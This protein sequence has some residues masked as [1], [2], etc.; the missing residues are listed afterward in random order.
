MCPPSLPKHTQDHT[1]LFTTTGHRSSYTTLLGALECQSERRKLVSFCCAPTVTRELVGLLLCTLQ[2]CSM[3]RGC[4]QT[5]QAARSQLTRLQNLTLLH[6]TR[7]SYAKQLCQRR[8]LVDPAF[9]SA[10]LRYIP[11]KA[12]NIYETWRQGYRR[13]WQWTTRWIGDVAIPL[14]DNIPPCLLET[15]LAPVSQKRLLCHASFWLQFGQAARLDTL[16]WKYWKHS[17]AWTNPESCSIANWL[18]QSRFSGLY[19]TRLKS[20]VNW[21]FQGE[22]SLTYLTWD[23]NWFSDSVSAFA[24]PLHLRQE[25]E[26]KDSR[27]ISFSA[28]RLAAVNPKRSTDASAAHIGPRGAKAA[29]MGRVVNLLAQNMKQIIAIHSKYTW[30]HMIV[31]W[32]PGKKTHYKKQLKNSDRVTPGKHARKPEQE[33][34]GMTPSEHLVESCQTSCHKFQADW[35]SPVSDAGTHRPP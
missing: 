23:R 26:S 22:E 33:R 20:W 6:L 24:S 9:L 11:V 5:C 31:W 27:R 30:I 1:G 19:R 14:F 29:G 3:K 35:P 21:E 13:W 15:Q 34:R 12:S 25:S 7:L 17:A 2:H 32:K 10:E 28:T 4:L 18:R 8:I 16:L